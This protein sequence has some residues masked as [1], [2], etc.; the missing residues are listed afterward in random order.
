MQTVT[1]A[2]FGLLIAY[3]VPGYL[4]LLGASFQ[5]EWISLLLGQR[6]GSAPS[7]AGVI[8]LTVIAV[9]IGLIASTIRW[10]IIDS[11]HHCLG[12]SNKK[13]D[14]AQLKSRVDGFQFL[15]ESHYRYYQFYGNCIVSLPFALMMRWSKTGF[16]WLE[17]FAAVFLWILFFAA[18]RDS[19]RK[20]YER[21]TELL[22]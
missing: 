4:F 2:N 18:T 7:V 5:N 14:F 16:S 8:L 21:V 13:W 12:L 9:S 6:D 3:V 1:N 17:F 19:I 11:I 20:Y 22:S 10:L 15:V